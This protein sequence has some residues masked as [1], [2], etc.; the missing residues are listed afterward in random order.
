MTLAMG[1]IINKISSQIFH[2]P[3]PPL[4]KCSYTRTNIFKMGY[5]NGYIK[6]T[7]FRVFSCLCLL[8]ACL[9]PIA[10]TYKSHTGLKKTFPQVVGPKQASSNVG[11]HFPQIGLTIQCLENIKSPSNIVVMS[12]N[13]SKWR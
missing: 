12:T 1:D 13:M 4:H 2:L 9:L 5:T 10:A 8:Y 11:A 7:I 6:M 3:S